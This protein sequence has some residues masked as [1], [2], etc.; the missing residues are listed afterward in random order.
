MDYKLVIFDLDGTLMPY[1]DGSCGKWHKKFLPNVKEKIEELQNQGIQIGIATNQSS[2][3]DVMD[4]MSQL[5]FVCD[6][7]G[8]KQG[9]VRWATGNYKKPNPYMIDIVGLEQNIYTQNI[10]LVGDQES[11][12]L[13][14]QNAGV[15]FAWAKEFFGWE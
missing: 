13:A 8:I 7:L 2:K 3:R 15:G 14:A 5:N 9:L 12:K 10:L 4:I 6:E 11:D 1:R